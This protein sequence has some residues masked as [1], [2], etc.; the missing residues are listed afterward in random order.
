MKPRTL[1]LAAMGA[2]SVAL[3]ACASPD[4]R[5]GISLDLRDAHD[6]APCHFDAEIDL[7]LVALSLRLRWS[8]RA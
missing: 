8:A 4:R 6:L 2:I 7:G 5:A 3:I 1:R